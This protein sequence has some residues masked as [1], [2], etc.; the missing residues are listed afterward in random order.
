MHGCSCFVSKSYYSF[1]F[2]AYQY[3][4]VI[5]QHYSI[6]LGIKVEKNKVIVDNYFEDLQ[7]K[8]SLNKVYSIP[9]GPTVGTSL[10]VSVL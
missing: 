3:L 4:L 7:I 2:K 5:P 8:L 1:F 6:L 9:L 10:S